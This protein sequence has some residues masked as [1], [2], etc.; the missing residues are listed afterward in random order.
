MKPVDGGNNEGE[1]VMK[2]HKV[3]GKKLVAAGTLGV[4]MLGGTALL[5]TPAHAGSSTWKKVAIGA[6][7]ITGYGLLKGKGKVA[8]IG[9]AATAG[10]YYMYKKDKKEEDQRND[11]NWRHNRRNR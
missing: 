7:A 4:M 2:N 3:Q 9:A 1:C 8:T 5:S 11:W 10:S 6:A